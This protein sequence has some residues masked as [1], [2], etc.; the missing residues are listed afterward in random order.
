MV[1]GWYDIFLPAQIDD[2]HALRTAG[3][4][5]RLTIGPWTHSSPGAIATSLRDGL[6]WF[7]G[8]LG[9]TSG[10]HPRDVVRVFVMGARRWVEF[11]EWPPPSEDQPWY[12]NGHGVLRPSLTGDSPPD[13]F[14]Y[15]PADP[16]P[17]IGGASL[18]W[19]QAGPKDQRER[20]ARADVLT[21]TSDV[22]TDDLTVIG[23]LRADLHVRSTREHCDFFVR[24]C[25][26]SP[27]GRSK[28]LSDGMV[29]LRP[30]GQTTSGDGSI[31][32]QIAMW[33]TAT[34]FSRGH[35][36]RF[37]VSSGAHP[38]YV[39]NTGTGESLGHATRLSDADQEVLHDAEHPSCLRLPVTRL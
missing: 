21:Y 10:G 27:K 33:P 36:I 31:A 1:G 4:S 14:R 29:R 32:I 30:G 3:R 24:L 2:Y 17:A 37:Q 12:L 6:E 23:P 22:L 16:T 9:E 26:V 18:D 11:R 19:S 38:L 39:R 8:H 13:R 15:N 25:D 34:M 20:E 5:V 7:D 28:N 35:R